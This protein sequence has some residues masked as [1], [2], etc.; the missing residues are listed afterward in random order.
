MASGGDHGCGCLILWD[1]QSW[2]ISSRV[3]VHSAAV[4]CI[5]DLGDGEN[6]ATGSYDKHINLFNR[7][8]GQ[9][10]SRY[11]HKSN[12]NSIVITSDKR[13]LVSAC[14]ENTMLVWNIVRTS[15]VNIG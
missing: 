9:V 6:L 15:N 8:K 4:T 1:T 14:L 5:V 3:Q 12:V 10:F 13:R 11:N 2:T 7:W